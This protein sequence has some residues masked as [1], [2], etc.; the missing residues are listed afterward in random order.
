MS[1]IILMKKCFSAISIYF[2]EK[3][4]WNSLLLGWGLG[5]RL[6]TS[7]KHCK[8]YTATFQL[9]GGGRPQEPLHTLFQ[10]RRGTWVEPPTFHKLAGKLPHKKES[11]VPGRIRTRFTQINNVKKLLGA[12]SH[13]RH[14][15]VAFSAY[16]W[17]GSL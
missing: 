11:K 16:E 8:E 14:C 6:F 4:P 17:T 12:M 13:F 7:H 9:T 2:V 3:K 5:L 10:I 1:I 15:F